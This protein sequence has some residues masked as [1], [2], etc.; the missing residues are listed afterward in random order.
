MS[1]GE[2]ILRKISSIRFQLE[3]DRRRRQSISLG[4]VFGIGA[5]LHPALGVGAGAGAG[6]VVDPG[7][8]TIEWKTQQ[9]GPMGDLIVNSSLP[10][11]PASSRRRHTQPQVPVFLA[12]HCRFAQFGVRCCSE[13]SSG[14]RIS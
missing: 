1:L 14:Y 2:Q 4:A 3:S 9:A 13:C 8:T 12:S 11:H 5:G 10:A 7:S 6:A